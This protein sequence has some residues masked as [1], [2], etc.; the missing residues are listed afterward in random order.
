MLVYT[1]RAVGRFEP[2]EQRV[3]IGAGDIGP[4]RIAVRAAHSAGAEPAGQ[5]IVKQNFVPCPGS[6]SK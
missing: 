4:A 2:G 1:V 3:N 6:L 5:T